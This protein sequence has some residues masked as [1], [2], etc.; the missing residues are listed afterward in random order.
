MALRPAR[1]CDFPAVQQFV[2]GLS[3]GDAPEP[4]LQRGARA[5]RSLEPAM[6]GV[7]A[8]LAV[9]TIATCAVFAAATGIVG[10]TVTLMGLLVLPPRL[11]A[12]YD[13]K[14]SAGA[15]S[16]R[17]GCLGVLIPPS[18]MLILY[19]ATAGVSVVQLYLGA[20][21]PGIMLSLMYIGYVMIGASSTPSFPP[22]CPPKS[23]TCPRARSSRCWP[24]RFF[25][26]GDPD[27]D[28][29]GQHPVRGGHAY[30]G[31]RSRFARCGDPRRRPPETELQAS[32][33]SVSSRRTTSMVCWLLVGSW[34]F[35]STFATLGGPRVLEG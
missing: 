29:A 12:G 27:R 9:A 25:P 33:E 7:P 5:L 34:V 18:M 32:G 15:P 19:G 30:R 23:A 3:G 17:A 13:V 26:A 14:V 24:P 35:A 28:G 1:P 10:A 31:G 8:A 6:S 22:S 11:K 21:I 4:L 2:R 16:P 20:L